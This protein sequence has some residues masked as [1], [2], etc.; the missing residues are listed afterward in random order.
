M[1]V[2]RKPR[3]ALLFMIASAVLM[4]AAA[5]LVTPIGYARVLLASG[6]V[7]ASVASYLNASVVIGRVIWRNHIIRASAAILLFVL[8][9][10]ALNLYGF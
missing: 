6:L 5:A 1:V 3:L 9:H 4:V 2:R 7:L 10:H 8:A